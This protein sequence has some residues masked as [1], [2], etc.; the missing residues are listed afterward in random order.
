[1]P[2]Q[3]LPLSFANANAGAKNTNPSPA[4]DFKASLLHSVLVIA[5]KCF[6]YPRTV[7]IRNKTAMGLQKHWLPGASF[8]DK[9]FHV[10]SL[11]FVLYRAFVVFREMTKNHM[12]K[13][14][15]IPSASDPGE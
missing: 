5:E 14:A 13:S 8:R 2:R 3:S 9:M 7:C 12:P 10:L 4:A 11:L 6:T 1:M 15:K